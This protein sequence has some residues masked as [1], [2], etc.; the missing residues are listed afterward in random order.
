MPPRPKR[1]KRWPGEK[2]SAADTLCP[3][4]LASPDPRPA[5][6]SASRAWSGIRGDRVHRLVWADVSHNPPPLS[7]PP[8]LVTLNFEVLLN[9]AHGQYIRPKPIL[10][11]SWCI[12]HWSYINGHACQKRPRFH[13]FGCNSNSDRV[14]AIVS[15]P[16]GCT[17]G[18][19][20]VTS[21]W[22]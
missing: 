9:S 12:D 5:Q 20:C 14:A 21:S 4:K 16:G 19:E 8:A 18:R 1:P 13:R 3:V 15:S 11:Y 10:P 17:S 2:P 22:W 6:A 7:F